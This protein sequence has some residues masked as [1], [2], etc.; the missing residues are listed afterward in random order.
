MH[1]FWRWTNALNDQARSSERT[2]LWINMDETNVALFHGGGK[3]NV[4]KLWTRGAARL[5][6]V[7]KVTRSQ[8]RQGFTHA[9][10]VCSDRDVQHALPQIII[11]NEKTLTRRDWN[12]V[13]DRLPR[14]V[15]VLRCKKGW[16]STQVMLQMIGA[17]KTVLRPYAAERLPILLLDAATCHLH[18]SIIAACV[19]CGMKYCLV[20]ARCTWLLQ[21]CDTHVFQRYKGFMRRV[22]V[23]MQCRSPHRRPGMVAAIDLCCRTIEHIMNAQCWRRAFLQTGVLGNQQ[24]LSA[25]VLKH[26]GLPEPPL[27]LPGLP[28]RD[29]ISAMYPRGFRI[30]FAALESMFAATVVL[31]GAAEPVAAAP[32]L[33]PLPPPAE[34]PPQGYWHGRTRS[35]SAQ[36]LQEAGPSQSSRGSVPEADLNALQQAE[37][38]PSASH[39]LPA[40][41]GAPAPLPPL[42]RASRLPRVIPWVAARGVDPTARQG[43][44]TRTS[45]RSQRSRSPHASQT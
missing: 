45:A 14:N 37:P 23:E 26:S 9:A 24:S 10:M 29:D 43:P 15:F 25:A 33:P 17:L 19:R 13:N 4:M 27:L 20:P 5:R 32:A 18:S 3:G 42:P 39:P 41:T 38:C 36:A 28:S 35:T 44:T 2:P 30:P 8:Q 21:P 22:F 40:A 16:N 1:A 6:P 7:Q 34:A 12:V 31:A 11:C